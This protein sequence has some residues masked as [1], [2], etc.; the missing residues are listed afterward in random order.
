M[1]QILSRLTQKYQSG[2]GAAQRAAD[3]LDS[4]MDLGKIAD[5]LE[6]QADLLAGDDDA[7]VIRLI[8]AILSQAIKE[9]V[10]D[11]QLAF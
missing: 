7:P 5:D 2:E 9:K 8:N 6:H 1:N 10:S 3:Q 11:I 4:E